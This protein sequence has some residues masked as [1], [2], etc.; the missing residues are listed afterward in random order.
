MKTVTQLYTFFLLLTLAFGCTKERLD[1]QHD[2]STDL[3]FRGMNFTGQL[4]AYTQGVDPLGGTA[5]TFQLHVMK[6]NGSNDV[7]I[8]RNFPYDGRPNWSPGGQKITFTSNRDSDGNPEVYII[9]PDGSGEVNLTN[10]G[11]RDAMSVFSP[12][13]LYITFISERDSPGSGDLFIM[14]NDGNNVRNLTQTPDINDALPTWSPD[15]SRIA[16]QSD[17]DGFRNIHVMDASSGDHLYQLT[18]DDLSN[19]DFAAWSPDGAR[20]A[21]RSDR[22]G[23]GEIYVM[24]ADGSGAPTRLTDYA[25]DDYY[26]AWSPNSNRIAFCR[27]VGENYNYDIFVMKDDGSKVTRVTNNPHWDADPNWAVVE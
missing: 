23:N 21:F 26:P 4:I 17:R 11:A 2:L 3:E 14:D 20:I 18:D 10:N 15:G 9:N 5:F 7:E 13:G 27:L 12:D 8:T 25:G 22:D 16:Y 19:N 1:N 6:A 24:N